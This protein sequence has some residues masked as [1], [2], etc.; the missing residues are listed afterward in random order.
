MDSLYK[1]SACDVVE[2]LKSGEVSS[3]DTLECLQNRIE[4]VDPGINSLPTLC[5]ERARRHADQLQQLPLEQRGPLCG[6]PVT[7]KDLTAVE[8]VRTTSGSQVF[9]GHIPE[10]SDRLVQQIESHGG[11]VYAKSNTPEFGTGGITFNNV[12]GITRSPYNTDYASG[13]SS[14]G[15]AAS[16]ASGCAWLSHGSDMAGSLRTPASFCGV[17]SLRPSPGRIKSDSDYTPYDFL[18]A[19]GPMARSIADL[20]L[21]ADVMFDSQ[22][23]SLQTASDNPLLPKTIAVS[24]DLGITDVSNEIGDQFE[25]FI[26]KLSAL[27]V[28][29]VESS[30]DLSGVHECFDT[31]RAH[32]YAIG[33]EEV[34][35]SHSQFLKPEVAWNIES[36]LSLT[37]SEIR[38]ATKTQGQLI[39]RGAQFMRDVDVLIVPAT[40]VAA[41]DAQLRYP[42]SDNDVPIPDYYRWLAIVYGITVTALPV[43][44]LPVAIT[45]TD[46]PFAVQLIGKPGGEFSLFQYA[47][48]I[49]ALCAWS[50]LPIDPHTPGSA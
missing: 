35:G 28:K 44:T 14:G 37:S 31:L 4:Q 42:G 13:G 24:R 9:A 3:H 23:E 20:A 49:E 36:G 27:P 32:S 47:K 19:E 1:L 26:G 33:L 6:L 46:L 30:P 8:G 18:S 45:S 7:I 12:F 34:L 25:A 38:E 21:F 10:Y 43:L 22:T 50:T 11:I 17:V 48:K 29:I 16:L 40:S 41:V 5:F 15:A 2:K 39:N